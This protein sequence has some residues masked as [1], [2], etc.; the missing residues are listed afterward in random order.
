MSGAVCFV[1]W[2]QPT[3]LSNK[4][5]VGSAM[6]IESL[7]R[8]SEPSEFLF[9]KKGEFESFL[10]EVACKMKNEDDQKD[11]NVTLVT[12]SHIAK[13][14]WDNLY[15][16]RVEFFPRGKKDYDAFDFSS[17][18]RHMIDRSSTMVYFDT[19]RKRHPIVEYAESRNVLPL[20]LAEFIDSIYLS[21]K[22]E[23]PQIR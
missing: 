4:L 15:F 19:S 8:L 20:N 5:K 3:E 16:D 13:C 18:Y 11:R 22:D 14:R 1:I 6:L 21:I 23:I 17:L 7:V 10:L 9:A 12:H 2:E